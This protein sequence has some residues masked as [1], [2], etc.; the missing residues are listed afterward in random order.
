MRI[1][2][3]GTGYVG[4]VVGTCLSDEGF[5]V[6][7]VDR[8]DEKIAMLN[9]G[10]VPIYEPGLED[11]LRR[12]YREGRLHF[13]SDGASAVA[14]ADIIFIAVGTPPADDGSAD[15]SVLEEFPG[16]VGREPHAAVGGGV[17]WKV[18][19]VHADSMVEAQEVGH[20]SAHELLAGS[21]LVLA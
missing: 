2:V 15:L 10:R 8:D 11:I 16:H 7:C 4:L 14:D 20:G 12:S 3:V 18:S 19:C 6:T 9:A 21:G 1:C 17:S 13:S 5:R